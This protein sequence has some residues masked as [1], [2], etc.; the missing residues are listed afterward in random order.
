MP[1]RLL[2]RSKAE[3]GDAPPQEAVLDADRVCIGRDKTCDIVINDPSVSRRHVRIVREG[4]LYFVEDTGSSCGTRVN[5]AA[6]P[7][8][9]TRLLKDRDVIAVGPYDVTFSRVEGVSPEPDEKTPLFAKRVVKDALREIAG[10]PAPFLRV[11][12]GP[13]EGKRFDVG[14]AA[15]LVIGRDT[16]A[17]LCLDGDDLVSRRHARIRRDW[18]G[19]T[20]EDLGSRNGIKVNRQK[21]LS[22]QLKDRDEIEIGGTRFLFVDPTT[23][24]APVA[25]VSPPE[26]AA[27]PVSSEPNESQK[28]PAKVPPAKV[29]PT[30]SPPIV[31]PSIA[32]PAEKPA[33]DKPATDKPAADKPTRENRLAETSPAMPGGKQAI[34]WRRLLPLVLVGCAA[35][36]AF[37]VVMVT[38]FVI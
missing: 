18:S 25:Q 21:V 19:A 7:P 15:E 10:E 12:N 14:D 17:D 29:P 23:P 3:T 24:V 5:G 30:E 20:L 1:I 31:N 13:L 36:F 34:Q 28:P 32:P 2:V 35:L 26:E 38:F 16:G 6:L 4:A 37:I 22:R 27:K 33:A 11:M 8:G 9:E